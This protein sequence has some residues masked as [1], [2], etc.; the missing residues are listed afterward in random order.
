MPQLVA[1]WCVRRVC[2]C[3]RHFNLIRFCLLSHCR[4]VFSRMRH[5]I[6]CY[7]HCTLYVFFSLFPLL[8]LLYF[9]VAHALI[10]LSRRTRQTKF[11]L[12]CATL[13]FHSHPS[14]HDTR[15][16]QSGLSAF[17]ALLDFNFGTNGVRDNT[18]ICIADCC[19]QCCCEL[20]GHTEAGG[21]RSAAAMATATATESKPNTRT[22]S[23]LSLGRHCLLFVNNLARFLGQK[24]APICVCV[25]VCD[26]PYCLS[27]L[28]LPFSVSASL[29]A[30]FNI[31]FHL[32]SALS[33]ALTVNATCACSICNTLF[34]RSTHKLLRVSL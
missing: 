34:S 1:S 11:G 8:F 10:Q 14:Q 16:S 5:P 24:D 4:Q 27:P 21:V 9:F 31:V 29:A 28:S 6:T 18:R 20:C 32:I 17:G 22:R 15:H 23:K 13:V 2:L 7:F 3:V 19:T 26:F 25:C 12:S 33:D 30:V